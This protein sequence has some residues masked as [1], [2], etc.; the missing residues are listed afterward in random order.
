MKKLWDKGIPLLQEI[1]EFTVGD[2]PHLDQNLIT[3]DCLG[4]IAHAKMLCALGIL[5]LDELRDIKQCLLAL[6]EKNINKTFSITTSDEDVHTA[7]ENYLR[8]QLGDLGKKI[9]TARSRNDQVVL[10]LRLYM[11]D[12]VLKI[13]EKNLELATAFLDFANTNQTVPFPGRTHFQKAMP[14]SFGL[15][16]GA[17]AESL[18]DNMILL[19]SSYDLINQSPLGSAAAYGVNLAIDRQLVTGLL[20]F[21][22]VQNN[23]LYVSN[24]RGKFESVIINSLTHIMND[25]SKAATDLIIFSAP[26]FGYVTIPEELCTGSSLMPQKKNPC[27][28]ELVRAKTATVMSNLFQTLEIIRGLPSGYN[29]DF[30]ETKEP[31][32]S[33]IKI[34]KQALS[35]IRLTL[36]KL[37]VNRTACL[38]AMSADLF[39]TDYALDLVKKGMPFRDAY[40]KVATELDSLAHVDPIENIISKKHL[41][42]T[43]NLGLELS[44]KKIAEFN[45]WVKQEEERITKIVIQLIED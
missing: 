11:R 45:C 10:D 31:L 40:R 8:A 13:M 12:H 29:R 44:Y 37:V 34:T 4:S 24:S 42:A 41:G 25:L 28:L 20:G 5:T 1:E 22:K 18:I 7:I 27:G 23:V 19:K 9:H 16:A 26:E 3:Y 2:D 17:F 32:M 21:S 35:V 43:G 38:N 33:S 39:A 14:A 6:I 15:W 30:Q 36:E